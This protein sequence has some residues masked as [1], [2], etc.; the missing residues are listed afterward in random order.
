[1]FQSKDYELFL[2]NSID[3]MDKMIGEGVPVDLTV[4][5]PPYDQLR[6]Y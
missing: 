5:S 3:I 6:S 2:G 4:T 1:M